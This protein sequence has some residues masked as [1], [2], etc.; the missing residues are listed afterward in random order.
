MVEI[1]FK[2]DVDVV[3]DF[4]MGETKPDIR[5]IFVTAGSG[6]FNASLRK[7]GIEVR[8]VESKYVAFASG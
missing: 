5:L 1:E 3:L 8:V 7:I 6:L 4:A 2:R